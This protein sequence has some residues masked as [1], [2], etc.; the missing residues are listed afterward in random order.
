MKKS[1]VLACCLGLAFAVSA[2]AP[3]VGSKEWCE[4][5]SDKPKGE[6]T[7]DEAKDYAKNCLFK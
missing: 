2:C 5:M 3:K 4:K 6:W 1:I 7:G